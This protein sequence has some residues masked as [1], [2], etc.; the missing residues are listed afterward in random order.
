MARGYVLKRWFADPQ[1]VLAAL[2]Q[3]YELE[4]IETTTDAGDSVPTEA[5]FLRDGQLW[6]VHHSWGDDL[7]NTVKIKVFVVDP[8]VEFDSTEEK[9]A[10]EDDLGADFHEEL[11]D[12]LDAPAVPVACEDCDYAFVAVDHDEAEEAKEIHR[13][14]PGNDD[15]TVTIGG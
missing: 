9:V 14:N 2:D 3:A 11:L 10:W 1:D 4:V 15:H 12:L 5:V 6:R 8:A 13:D 7:T